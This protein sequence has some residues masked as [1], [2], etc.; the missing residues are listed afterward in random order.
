MCKSN[1]KKR[2]IDSDDDSFYSD[3]DSSYSDSASSHS[4]IDE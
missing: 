3:D 2:R 1:S 4:E